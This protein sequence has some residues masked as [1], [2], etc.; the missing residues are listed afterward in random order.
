[1]AT[2]YGEGMMDK[3]PEIIRL[4]YRDI[5]ELAVQILE[6]SDEGVKLFSVTNNY[7]KGAKAVEYGFW[8]TCG[9]IFA[10]CFAIAIGRV[11][12]WLF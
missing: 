1:M 11:V 5:A 8:F 2:G 3:K 4:D 9:G 10:I 12:S 7:P 6:K